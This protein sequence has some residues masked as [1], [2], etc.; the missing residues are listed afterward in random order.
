MGAKVPGQCLC[1]STI[2]ELGIGSWHRCPCALLVL[3]CQFCQC[4]CVGKAPL[5]C[6]ISR[7]DRWAA[8]W[9]WPLSS[10]SSASAFALSWHPYIR[11]VFPVFLNCFIFSS[12]TL[13]SPLYLP[14]PLD[15]FLFSFGPFW[16]GAWPSIQELGKLLRRWVFT[17]L[18]IRSLNY[19]HI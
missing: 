1:A 6:N 17:P 15:L 10:I 14:L 5:H 7:H 3:L 9:D 19:S 12:Q 2:A 4:P 16:F 18:V 8:A 11:T 13:S